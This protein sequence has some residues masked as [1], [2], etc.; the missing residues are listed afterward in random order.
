MRISCRSAKTNG[1]EEGIQ[2]ARRL[3]SR[4]LSRTSRLPTHLDI[5]ALHKAFYRGA[6]VGHATSTPDDTVETLIA[7]AAES[8]HKRKRKRRPA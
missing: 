5:P 3:A 6:S 8:M 4:V 7:R 2:F 1:I